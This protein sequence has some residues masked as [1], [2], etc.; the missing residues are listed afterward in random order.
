MPILAMRRGM[1][2]VVSASVAREDWHSEAGLEA[3][4]RCVLVD[5]WQQG[6]QGCVFPPHLSVGAPVF[7]AAYLPRKEVT[8]PV[9]QRS[10]C[11]R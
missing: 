1:E 11:R 8:Q 5:T 7:G 4:R 10:S 9:S 6:V 3:L 2:E